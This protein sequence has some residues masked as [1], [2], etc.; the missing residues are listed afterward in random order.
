MTHG[1]P[2]RLGGLAGER[3]PGGIG[4]GAGDHH[5]YALAAGL[6]QRFQC[7]DRGLGIERVEDRLD[8]D[9]IGAA[10]DQGRGG[11]GVVVAQLVECH[12]ALGGVIDVRR[13]RCGA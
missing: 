2:E 10:F 7:V 8:Q 1:V 13:Q 5:R 9:Q 12:V 6:E 11:F 3:T 4:N